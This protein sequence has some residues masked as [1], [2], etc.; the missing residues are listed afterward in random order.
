MRTS[1]LLIVQIQA[2]QNMKC[3]YLFD[4]LELRFP[5]PSGASVGNDVNDHF[6]PFY[7]PDTGTVAKMYTAL[8]V[9]KIYF[10]SR[11]RFTSPTPTHWDI[12]RV[13]HH[14]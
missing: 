9:T 3:N 12:T 14:S 8:Q 13:K 6:Y 2:Y 7:A 5:S 10:S 1:S 11:D 4:Y